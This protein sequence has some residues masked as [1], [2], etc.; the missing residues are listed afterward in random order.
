METGAGTLAVN[1]SAGAS[2]ALTT[3]TTRIDLTTVGNPT[4]AGLT[5]V[6]AVDKETALPGEVLTYTVTYA[7]HSSAALTN[8]VIFDNTPAFTRFSSAGHGALPNSIT[9]ITLSSPGVGAS[10]AIKWT[11]TGSLAPA[12]ASTVTFSVTVSQ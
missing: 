8:I 11:F 6:K 10:G 4:T 9:G 3:N 12:S 1:K 5:L 2:P 7:N